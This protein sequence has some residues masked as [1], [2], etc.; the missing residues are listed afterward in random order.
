MLS[1]TVAQ[2]A[3][4]IGCFAFDRHLLLL[5]AA[6]AVAWQ[7]SFVILTAAAAVAWQLSFV[8]LSNCQACH[9]ERHAVV[10]VIVHNSF[11][12]NTCGTSGRGCSSTPG[13][14]APA[15]CEVHHLC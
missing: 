4:G 14:A 5:T 12:Q 15:L 13:Y 10:L 3:I 9:A 2:L 7:L 8:K 6:P 1:Q 11:C